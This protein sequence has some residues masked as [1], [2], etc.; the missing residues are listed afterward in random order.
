MLL[1]DAV[2]LLDLFECVFYRND[3]VVDVGRVAVDAVHA[4]EL[5][6]VLAVEGHKVVVSHAAL[7]H[8][9]LKEQLVDVEAVY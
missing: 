9:V 5:V 3:L 1:H 4:Q 2:V 8:I 6:L 7:G